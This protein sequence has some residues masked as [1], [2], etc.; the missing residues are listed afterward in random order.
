MIVLDAS[1][2]AN[3][4]EGSKYLHRSSGMAKKKVDAWRSCPC[5]DLVKTANLH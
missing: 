2:Q 3:G 1:A 5:V 4:K